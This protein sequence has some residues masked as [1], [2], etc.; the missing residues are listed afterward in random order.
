[1]KKQSNLSRL[2]AYAGSYKI[3]TYL[4]WVLSAAGA[5][6]ALVPFWYIWR[7]LGEV[8]EVA[9]QYG[10]AVHVTHYGWMAVVFA[11]AAVLVYIT[12]LMCS[13]L[14]AFRIATN[15]RLAMTKHIVTL[16]LGAIEQFGSGKLRKIIHES[17]GAAETYLAHQLPDQYN[18]I[19]TPVGLLVLL[20]AFDWR[21]GLL[22]L[23]PVVLAFLIMATMTGK[24]MAEK[25]RQYG[26]ALESMSNEAVE[27]VRGIPVVKIFG[28]SV[29][30]FKKFKATIDEYEKWVVSYTKDLRL[31]MMFYTAAV[32]GVFAFLIVGGLLF[33]R[34]GVT[35][36]FLLNL[37]FYIIITPVI[38]LTLTRMMYMSESKMVVA[39]A[40]ARIDSVLEAAPMQVQAVPQHPQDASVALQNVRFSYDGKNEVIKDISLSIPAGQTVAFVGP[41]GGG[42]TT[43]ANLICRFFDPQGGQVKIGSV[44]VKHIA[45]EELMNTV[46]FVFQNSRLIKASILE[47]VRMGKPDATREEIMAALHNAQC[48][49][50]LEK[51][52]QG[53]DTVI[54][55]KGVY[56]SGGE[57]QRI[58]IARVMLK[59]APVVILDEATAFAD[60]DNESRVQ[61]AFSKLSQGKTVIMIAHRLSTV[62]GVDQIYVIEDGQIT[63]SGKSRELLEK[64]GVFSHMWQDYQTSV[65]WKVAKEVQ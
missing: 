23:A 14:A 60:P 63:E 16:P 51:L 45:K 40:L 64:G 12:G 1:M 65:Q 38:S 53:A 39:D 3:L 20:L 32:N 55:T 29:F 17:T 10:N 52:P 4:S 50:I 56:L 34:N 62:A 9:P 44:D 33:T 13:H 28:Q 35:S 7:I 5:L 42:K 21:L 47:N 15:L 37:L 61:A 54:G 25:M 46:S 2:L 24:R 8:I 59:N 58:A 48:D 26:N 36:E 49:D 22:S 57:Q 27:Y 43:L 41:S 31:P 11:V 19:A 6:L 30:S 18:A